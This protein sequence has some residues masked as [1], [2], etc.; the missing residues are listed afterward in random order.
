M[1][2]GARVAPFT[3][4]RTGSGT[5]SCHVCACTRAVRSRLDRCGVRPR[6]PTEDCEE[7]RIRA[8]FVASANTELLALRTAAFE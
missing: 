5:A 4:R 8:F 6:G 7:V 1:L 2:S 3:A